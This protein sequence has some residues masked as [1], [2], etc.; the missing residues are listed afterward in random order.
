MKRFFSLSSLYVSLLFFLTG[1]P[2]HGGTISG[3]VTDRG[4]S[5]PLAY[6]NIVIR[7]TNQGTTTDQSGYYVIQNIQSGEYTLAVSYMGY[8]PADTTVRIRQEESLRV[9]FRMKSRSLEGEEVVVTASRTR[10]EEIV[11]TS[12]LN[13]NP[14][15]LEIAPSFVEAD[16][17]RTLQRLPGVVSQNDFSAALVV[18]GGSP[19][20]NLILLDGI[21]VY[22]PY[23]FGGVFSAFNTDAIRDAEFQ[24]GGFPVRYG[25]RLSSVLEI[26]T[27]EGDP[28]GGILGT[29]WP[30]PD[31]FDLSGISADVSLLSSKAFI[32]GPIYKGG[33]FLSVRRTYFDQIA[34]LAHSVSDTIPELPYYFYDVQWKA[35]SQLTQRHRVDIQGYHGADNLTLNIGGMGPGTNAVDFQWDW[36]NNTSGI[37]LRSILK[38]DVVLESRLARSRYH[39]DVDF[40]QTTT[41]STGE[42]SSTRFLITNIL[43][44]LTLSERLDWKLSPSHR[45]QGGLDFKQFEFTF[46][47]DSDETRLLDEADQPTLTSFYLQDTWKVNALLN[48]QLGVR[49]S[50]Y[51]NSDRLWT[52]IR[53]GVKYRPLENTALKGSIGSYSQFLFTSNQDDAVLR[54][55]DFWNAVPDYLDPQRA[56]HYILGVEQWIGEGHKLS[57]ETYYK[58]YSNVLDI[59]PLQNVYNE[60]DDFIS[61]TGEAYG[62]EALFK[63]SVGDLSGWFSYSWSKTVKRIDLDGDGEVESEQGEVYPPK[64]DKRHNLNLVLNYRINRTNSVGLTWNWSSGQPYTPVVGKMYGGN[65]TS[66]WFRPYQ[67]QS[68]IVGGRNSARYPPYLRGDISYTRRVNW[69]GADGEWKVQI[70]N[71]TNHFN[72]LL[73]QWDHTSSPSR[74]VATSMF[75]IIPTMGVSFD[76]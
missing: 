55:V 49:S 33:Y 5:D 3:Y 8:A 76:I 44:D 58:P 20:E 7:G 75:P 63:R 42:Q 45:L 50:W 24:A 59:N 4:S 13:L 57:L 31:Y 26:F 27:K 37:L 54:I 56:M 29:W 40:V 30:W 15:E 18:R 25:G 71:F 73:Y 68:N 64:Y 74:A 23:H 72:V 62:I 22:N 60:Q 28:S 32:E 39:F 12:R 21:E 14:R 2:I 43:S 1:V 38:P 9:D 52:D 69:F 16:L 48:L 6:A 66:G 35:H 41:D 47:F 65:G 17:F 51:S 67:E 11:E 53:G 10:F 36:G 70:I 34:A 19:D 46:T 61:G